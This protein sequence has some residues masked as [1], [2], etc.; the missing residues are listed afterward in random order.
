MIDTPVV[1]QSLRET[2]LGEKKAAK[3]TFLLISDRSINL[4]PA[5]TQ[6]TPGATP[7]P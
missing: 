1:S 7:T 4:F 3:I 2:G 6:S 5:R